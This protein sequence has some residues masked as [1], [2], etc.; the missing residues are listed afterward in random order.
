MSTRGR[1]MPRRLVLERMLRG[2]ADQAARRTHLVHDVVAGVDAGA[3]RRC[4]RSAVPCGCRCRWDRPARTRCSRCSRP[5]PCARASVPRLRA[6]RGSPRSLVVGD[7]QRVAVEHRALEARVRAHVL[8]HLLAQ[9]AGVAVGGEA[10]E[11][12]PEGFPG[13]ERRAPAL[14]RASVRIGVKKPTKVKPVH[15]ANVTHRNC[16]RDLARELVRVPGTA[17]ELQAR[18]A[19]AFGEALHP[20]EGLGPHRL[21]T[22]VAAP[23]PPADGGEEEQ[24]QRRDDQQPGEEDE[25][26]R[27]EH[28]A[29][30]EELARRQVEQHRLP[31]VPVAATAADSRCRAAP[32]RTA[33]A[34]ARSGPSISRG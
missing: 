1:R 21:R 22:G 19:I 8:A 34:A 2:V 28:Q 18:G 31:A 6:P 17:I 4:I 5:S 16:L 27:P 24:R 9:V 10:V 20:Q 26:L 23:Q 11:Q 32:T 3:R 29:E 14:P 15:S 30:D 33:R 12:D 7:D 25:I 13:P